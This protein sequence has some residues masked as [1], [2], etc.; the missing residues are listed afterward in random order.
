MICIVDLAQIYKSNYGY[1]Y[2]TIIF[3]LFVI[4][5]I[6]FIEY[7]FCKWMR[8][9]SNEEYNN[10]KFI[11]KIFL[12]SI[13]SS[14]YNLFCCLEIL[15]NTFYF[16]YSIKK[17]Q[18][19]Y[20]EHIIRILISIILYFICIIILCVRDGIKDDLALGL[21]VCYPILLIINIF[22]LKI[23]SNYVQS[24]IQFCTFIV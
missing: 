3:L 18:K 8:M 5:F 22:S 20:I 16:G 23:I 10:D 14:V 1:I 7:K 21:V 13:L 19:F 15:K 6:G 9:E 2:S 12:I 4:G 24:P 17:F 11:L